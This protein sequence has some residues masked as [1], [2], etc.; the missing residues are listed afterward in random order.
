MKVTLTE[1][2]CTR[3]LEL[4][5]S[6]IREAIAGLPLREALE[7][8]DTNEFGEARAAVELV[9]DGEIVY[10]K[11]RLQG[12]LQMACSRCIEATRVPIDDSISVTFMPKDRLPGD[13]A[14]PGEAPDDPEDLD[15][16]DLFPY[17]GTALDLTPLFRERLILSIPIA[18]LCREACKGLCPQC[19]TDQNREKCACECSPVDPRLAVLEDLKV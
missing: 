9:L 14:E 19:G 11:G 15:D 12:W 8:A 18:P 13:L 16:V 2:P 3:E 17:E 5:K 6:F 7:G 4:G 1:L 10:V